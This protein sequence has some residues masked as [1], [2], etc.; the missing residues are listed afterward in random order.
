MI[1]DVPCN[2]CTRCCHGDAIRILPGEDAGQWRTVPHERWPSQ[3]MLDHK[4]DGDCIYLGDRGCTIHATKPRMCK[5]M[6]CR[7]IAMAITFT[8]ARKLGNVVNVWRRGRELLKEA[9]HEG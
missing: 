1:A 5:E 7:R 6:D 9:V 4:P 8:Q 2:G 3:R